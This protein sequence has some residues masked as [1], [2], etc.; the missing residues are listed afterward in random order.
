M[1][2]IRLNKFLA[3]CGVCSRRDA[4]KLI[5]QGRV[6]INGCRADLGTQVTEGDEVRADGKLLDSYHLSE[7]EE[8]IVLAYYKPMGVVC[9]ERDRHAE[10]KVTD[11]IKAPVR[12]TYAGRLD[13]DSEGLLLLTNDGN[14]I[15]AM[16]RG[17]H[18]HEKEYVV[19]V[20][21][22][23]TADFL[24]KLEQGIYLKELDVTTRPCVTKQTGT[25]TFHITL[26]QG[27]NRQIRRMCQSCGFQVR[28]LRRIR[29]MNITLGDLKPG[30]YRML[31][32]EETRCLC[33]M[34]HL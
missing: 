30:E 27:L 18:C 28:S 3:Q 8:R 16:M 31:G 1:D 34:C 21:Q 4:D 7:P 29:V 32:Q 20:A 17:S 25:Y 10:K 12:V 14:L 19:K 22:K 23:V 11:L 5:T 6:T 2:R 13:K 33:S 15:N 24:R 26:T 9:T